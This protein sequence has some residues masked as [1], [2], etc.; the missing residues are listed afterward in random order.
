MKYEE[1][2][3]KSGHLLYH[4]VFSDG[5][6]LEGG[7]FINESLEDCFWSC[8][9]SLYPL[10]FVNHAKQGCENCCLNAFSIR[11]EHDWHSNLLQFHTTSTNCCAKFKE[12]LIWVVLPSEGE[13]KNFSNHPS[14]TDI[15][16][17]PTK[18]NIWRWNALV[19]I[20]VFK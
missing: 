19:I 15:W 3:L 8:R 17:T 9:T 11:S 13:A 5:N 14:K 7:L 16:I 20:Q 18:V 12:K 1:N 2:I 4:K 10:Y 6:T